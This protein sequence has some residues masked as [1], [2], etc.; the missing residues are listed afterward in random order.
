MSANSRTII[1]M[2]NAD[3]YHKDVAFLDAEQVRMNY[4]GME[5]SALNAATHPIGC[6]RLVVDMEDLPEAVKFEV[7]V[8]FYK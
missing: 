6:P 1:R 8:E 7:I 2:W 4:A 5:P 3:G